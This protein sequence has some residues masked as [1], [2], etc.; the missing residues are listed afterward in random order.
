MK[1]YY[2]I[3]SLHCR[4]CVFGARLSYVIFPI[5]L[6]KFGSSF[7]TGMATIPTFSE[8]LYSL[9]RTVVLWCF[10]VFFVTFN[11]VVSQFYWWKQPQDTDKTTDMSQV[12]DKLYHIMLDIIPFI[13]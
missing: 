4:N 1:L 11:S 8:N 3:L 5:K 6:L 12:T 10:F 13:E 7:I 2:P 9:A